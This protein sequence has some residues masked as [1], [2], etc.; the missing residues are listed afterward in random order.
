MQRL[1]TQTLKTANDFEANS[2]EVEALNILP[3][4]SIFEA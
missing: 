3:Y 2:T 1:H 4:S